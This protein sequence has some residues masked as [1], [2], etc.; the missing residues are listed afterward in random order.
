MHEVITISTKEE[1]VIDIDPDTGQ[2]MNI[3]FVDKD[4][5]MKLKDIRD[6]NMMMWSKL[7]SNPHAYSVEAIDDMRRNIVMTAAVLMEHD[8]KIEVPNKERTPED[9][10]KEGMGELGLMLGSKAFTGA[11]SFWRRVKDDVMD[12]GA[13]YEEADDE[14]YQRDDGSY[15]FFD[16]DT[17]EEVECDE[18]GEEI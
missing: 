18:H 9:V 13:N 2:P 4:L 12:H 15:F 1:D 17:G 14:Y 11:L 7:I 16:P 5:P 10:I 8:V 6:N 3:D